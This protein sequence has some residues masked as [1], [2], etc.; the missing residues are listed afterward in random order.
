MLEKCL[1]KRKKK[2]AQNNW[3]DEIKW[4]QQTTTK[5]KFCFQ[6][7]TAAGN[8]SLSKFVEIVFVF[9]TKVTISHLLLFWVHFNIN[10]D[11][12]FIHLHCICNTPCTVHR[13]HY[14]YILHC[15]SAKPAISLSVHLNKRKPKWRSKGIVRNGKRKWKLKR[16]KKWTN[17]FI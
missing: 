11:S 6:S 7:F 13:A 9:S 16:K 17:I 14:M 12:I 3:K 2:T 8:K 1:K 4:K 15:K 10:T 5:K